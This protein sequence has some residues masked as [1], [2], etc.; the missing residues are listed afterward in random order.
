MSNSRPGRL[1]PFPHDARADIL[2]TSIFLGHVGSMCPREG[3]PE[4]QLLGE[5]DGDARGLAG[6]ASMFATGVEGRSELAWPG[7]GAHWLSCSISASGFGLGVFGFVVVP[8][9]TDRGEGELVGA[10]GEEHS[11]TVSATMATGRP[12][13]TG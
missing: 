3:A 5:R 10:V 4:L 11:S 8:E 9:L 1:C 12:G 7:S 6:V 2:V 13:R